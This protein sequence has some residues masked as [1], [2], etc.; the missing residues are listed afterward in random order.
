MKNIEFCI[1]CGIIIAFRVQK[2]HIYIL[3]RKMHLYFTQK[4]KFIFHPEKYIYISPGKMHLYSPGKTH[5]Y[6]IHGQLFG[7]TLNDDKH[8]W[9]VSDGDFKCKFLSK[10][11][12]KRNI[13]SHTKVYLRS[14]C[15]FIAKLHHCKNFSLIVFIL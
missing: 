11:M 13:F 6:F 12:L 10:L 5:L 15:N 2:M 9:S 7:P 14:N 3:P 8:V 1:L 4:N